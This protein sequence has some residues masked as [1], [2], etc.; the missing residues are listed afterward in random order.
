M[1][2]YPYKNITPTLGQGVFVADGSPVIG[3]VHIGDDSSVW[4]NVTVRGDVNYIRIGS[5][6]NIQDGST[7]HV[8]RNTGPTHIGN[9]VTVGHNVVI[10]ACTISDLVLIGMGSVLLDGAVIES[11]VLVGAGTLVPPNKKIPSGTLFMGSP[12]KVIRDLTETELA[13]FAV[14]ADNY[15]Q[16]K[17]IY[18][19]T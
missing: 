16:L 15:V 9:N 3:D 5:R 1:N 17:N 6:T 2:I 18:L 7:V 13:F 8:T 11:H 10:H 4:F 19:A 14:S 12:G